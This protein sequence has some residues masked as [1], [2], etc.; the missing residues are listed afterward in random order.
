ML[1]LI[2]RVAI[3]KYDDS[4]LEGYPLDKKV[5]LLLDELLPLVK[6]QRKEDEIESDSSVSSGESED[7]Y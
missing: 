6:M 4:D 7:E 1:E 2:G 5:E 3:Y